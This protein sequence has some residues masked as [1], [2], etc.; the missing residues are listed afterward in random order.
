M[1]LWQ[2]TGLRPPNGPA[3]L[4]HLRNL[5]RILQEETHSAAPHMCMQY[6]ATSQAFILVTLIGSASLSAETTREAIRFFSLVIDSEEEDFLED[7]AFADQLISFVR[8]ATAAGANNTTPDTETEPIELLFTIAAKLRQRPTI[9]V[10]WFRSSRDTS[11]RRPSQTSVLIPK[12]QEFPLMYLLLGYVHNSGKIGD[13]ARTGLLYILELAG[14]ADK[15]EKWIIESEL[16]TMMASGLGALYSQLSSKVSLSYPA[17]SKP[18]VLAFSDVIEPD[19]QGDAEPIFSATLQANLSTFASFLN[20][21]QDVLERCPSDDIKASLLDHFDFLFLRPLLYPSLVESSDNDSGS[22]VAVLTYLT[23][24]LEKLNETSVIRLLLRYMLAAPAQPPPPVKKPSRPS[25]L[26]QRRKSETLIS[27]NAHRIDDPSPDLVT[28]TN[29]LQGYLMSRNQQTVTASLRLLATLLRSWHEFANTTLMKVQASHNA[30]S[31]RPKLLH[32]QQ[33]NVLYSLAEDLLDD[34]AFE[35]LYESHL[36]DAQFM[37]ETHP[38]S[39]PQLLFP[40]DD[41]LEK[42]VPKK[43][44]IQRMIVPDDLLVTCLLALLENFLVNDIEVNLSLSETLATLASCRETSLEGWLLSSPSEAF[45]DDGAKNEDRRES[46]GSSRNEPYASPV[47]ARLESLVERIDRLRRDIQDFDIHLAERR[48]IFK[49]GGE[50]DDILAGIP[51]SRKSH[52]SHEQRKRSAQKD[53]TA[54]GSISGRLEASRDVSPSTSPRGRQEGHSS[55]NHPQPKSVVGRLSHLHLSP[56]PS[57]SSPL[58]R[59]YSPSP[60]RAQSISTTA[61]SPLPSPRGPPDALRQKIGL[62]ITPLGSR[63]QPRESG[64]SET[65][66]SY[67]ESF[68]AASDVVGGGEER[69]ISLSHLLTNVIILQEFILELAAIVQVRASLY[70]EVGLS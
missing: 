10:A 56:P 21:W 34:E 35:A 63:R 18:P 1:E 16:A 60:L 64:G 44:P 29:I 37:L 33:L 38:C 26:A 3:G 66:S 39:A 46:T 47:F 12:S 17:D 41:I 69:E 59:T 54:V 31:K 27:N 55:G 53:R 11:R 2:K 68:K 70:G 24:I 20:F 8:A 45:V 42:I 5:N 49:V 28:L 51:P 40:Y 50:I 9:P 57:S 14:R 52:E 58:E 22:S 13:F 6:V 25:T 65:S 4:L 32:D 43:R 7:E 61:S 19:H 30:S 67:S 23:Y 48:H 62:K 36:Q 15:L